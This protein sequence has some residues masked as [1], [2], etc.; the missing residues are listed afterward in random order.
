MKTLEKTFTKHGRDYTIIDRFTAAP[1]SNGSVYE[2]VCLEIQGTGKHPFYEL[3]IV[4]KNPERVMQGK[5]IEAR[6]AIAGDEDFG[7][8][9]WAYMSPRTMWEKKQ[10]LM[11][12]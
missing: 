10:T 1:N 4:K 5:V 3:S 9:A 6:E 11:L 12:G 8:L 2:Y 7:T